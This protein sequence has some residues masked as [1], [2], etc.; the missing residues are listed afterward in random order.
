MYAVNLPMA[1]TPPLRPQERVTV[2]T[3]SVRCPGQRDIGEPSWRSAAYGGAGRAEFRP[4]LARPARLFA[5]H[6]C[7]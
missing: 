5:G 1:P 7:G 6:R 2:R 4:T 3:P